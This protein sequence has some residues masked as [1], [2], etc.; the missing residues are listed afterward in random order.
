ML[1]RTNQQMFDVSFDS[2][3]IGKA[4]V[5]VTG[6]CLRVNA[7][8]ARMLGYP[9]D[10]LIG[11]HFADFTFP[12]DINAD[13]HLFAAVMRG[14]RVGYQIEK[15]YVR[16]DGQ[17]LD[18]LLSATC[19]RDDAGTPLQFISEI[20][21]L[22]DRNK[23]RRDLQDANARLQKLVVTDHV[24]GLYNRR[25]F[26]DIMSAAPREQDLA[27]LLIDLDNFKEIN[28]RL[29]HSAGDA[30]LM[31]VARR[32]RFQVRDC[33][34][35]ARIGG[36]E[37]AILLAGADCDLATKVAQ[38]VVRALCC[39]CEIEGETVRIGASIGVSSACGG[40]HRSDL[41]QQADAAL[42]IAKGAG[43]GQWRV[44]A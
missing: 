13:L 22:S 42:Y 8:L 15:R 17:V 31:E 14:E 36:D 23:T 30:A 28:D 26:E 39:S 11:M 4:I 34:V 6:H 2:T 25:G 33:D 5:A 32:L 7:S 38:R 37:F 20:V 12:D 27:V 9:Q 40:A 16:K 1:M 21:D 43:R 19:V 24:T 35:I 41:M 44:A 3:L 29:G 10:D 18:A